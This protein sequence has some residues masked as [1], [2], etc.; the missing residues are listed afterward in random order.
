[1]SQIFSVHDLET[2]EICG[3]VKSEMKDHAYICTSCGSQL[4][5]F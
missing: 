2:C 5:D 3:E 1:M 4:D